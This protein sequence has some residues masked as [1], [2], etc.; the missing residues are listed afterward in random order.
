MSEFNP[1][2]NLRLGDGET[3]RPEAMHDRNTI[4]INFQDERYSWL[5]FIV[6]SE[7]AGA[8]Y[9]AFFDHPYT[10]GQLVDAGVPVINGAAPSEQVKDLYVEYQVG[11]L[12]LELGKL[13][14][15]G[16]L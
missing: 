6:H 5:S 2:D 4:V 1:L 13:A 8:Q 9:Q 10:A 14:A 11:K 16:S 12:E 7:Y 15:G 3:P